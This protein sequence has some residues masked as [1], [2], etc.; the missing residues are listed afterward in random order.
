[1]I[2]DYEESLVKVEF[3]LYDTESD[4]EDD[5]SSTQHQSWRHALRPRTTDPVFPAEKV[6][7]TIH[8]SVAN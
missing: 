3:G 8:S 7:N 1:M 4:G 2:E 5:V 6:T